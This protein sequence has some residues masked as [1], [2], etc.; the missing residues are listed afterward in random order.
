MSVFSVNVQSKKSALRESRLQE[1]EKCLQEVEAAKDK[2]FKQIEDES[3]QPV[4][5]Y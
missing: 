1:A 3:L 5:K 2:V 4:R